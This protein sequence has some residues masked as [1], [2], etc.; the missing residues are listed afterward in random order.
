MRTLDRIDRRILAALQND[1]RL[2]NKQLAASVGLAPSSCLE[3]VRRLTRE[4]A[5]RGFHADVAPAALGIGLEA[6]I[7]VRLQ[8]HDR[9][10]V[11]AFR[12]HV[13]TL[14]EVV[15]FFHT[16]GNNDFLLRVVVRHVQHL[17]EFAL[18]A[19]TSQDEVAHIETTLVF[20]HHERWA[21][22]DFTGGSDD[23][24]L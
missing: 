15:G 7:A 16:A 17:R 3:R 19:L 11:R 18:D 13:D 10:M 5:L 9:E 22:P 12:A 24:N 21:L 14:P 1:A 6:I 20:E 23:D 8:R 2:S 4:G